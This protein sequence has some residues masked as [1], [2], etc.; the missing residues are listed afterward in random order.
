[1][2][3]FHSG[4]PDQVVP[5]VLYTVHSHSS[6]RLQQVHVA[7]SLSLFRQLVRLFCIS[8]CM[9]QRLQFCCFSAACSLRFRFEI[10]KQLNFVGERIELSQYSIFSIQVHILLYLFDHILLYL[11]YLLTAQIQQCRCTDPGPSSS[12]PFHSN[13]G[14]FN[15]VFSF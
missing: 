11:L 1:M 10:Y 7:L 2:A 4:D 15:P 9:A 8:Q 5:V 14:N 12:Q 13:S 6:R 3:S